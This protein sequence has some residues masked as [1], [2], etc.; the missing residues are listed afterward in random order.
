MSLI[1]ADG[2][3]VPQAPQFRREPDTEWGRA[4][5]RCETYDC[6]RPAKPG[7][8]WC[9]RCLGD[10]DDPDLICRVPGCDELHAPMNRRCGRHIAHFAARKPPWGRNDRWMR[11]EQMTDRSD[12][13][14]IVRDAY[15]DAAKMPPAKAV[16][17]IN[18]LIRDMKASKRSLCPPAKADIRRVHQ[19]GLKRGWR[20]DADTKTFTIPKEG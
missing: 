17:W 11:E 15:A 14:N 18:S 9:G 2:R 13:P 6:G 3:L 7:D 16:A 19:L 4:P 1:D 8:A 5:G 12:W 20:W 10:Y